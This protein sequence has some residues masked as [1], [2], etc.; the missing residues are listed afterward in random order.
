ML[1]IK[2]KQ[3]FAF[4]HLSVNSIFFLFFNPYQVHVFM[5]PK[6]EEKKGGRERSMYVREKLQLVSSCECPKMGIKPTTCVCALTG[7]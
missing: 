6:R 1:N 7:S 3:V 4:V 5:I 2:K